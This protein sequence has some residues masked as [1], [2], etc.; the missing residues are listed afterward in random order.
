MSTAPLSRLI[1]GVE[2]CRRRSMLALASPT[3]RLVTT[4]I[5]AMAAAKLANV[6][7]AGA[8]NPLVSGRTMIET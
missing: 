2:A 5:N 8:L 1:Q 4:I 7:S 6:T 3:S